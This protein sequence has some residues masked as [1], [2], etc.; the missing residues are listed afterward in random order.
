MDEAPCAR[1]LVQDLQITAHG[2]NLAATC[3]GWPKS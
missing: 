3:F 2:T 1:T